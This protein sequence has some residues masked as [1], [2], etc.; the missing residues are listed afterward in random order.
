M[1]LNPANTRTLLLVC[2]LI[3]CFLSLSIAC[4]Q[5]SF[6]FERAA[7]DQRAKRIAEY[8]TKFSSIYRVGPGVKFKGWEC[9]L[10]DRGEKTQ[11]SMSFVLVI[12]SKFRCAFAQHSAPSFE[13][14]EIG[15]R[16]LVLKYKHTQFGRARGEES[17]ERGLVRVPYIGGQFK[18]RNGYPFL[19]REKTGEN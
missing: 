17:I 8:F 1:S 7:V 10:D 12:G 13:V 18:L 2:F 6:G 3:E 14:L 16:D 4:A 19:S 5:E 15:A 9:S 11:M